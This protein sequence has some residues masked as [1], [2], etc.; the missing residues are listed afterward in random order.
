MWRIDIVKEHIK[1]KIANSVVRIELHRFGVADKE[2]PFRLNCLECRRYARVKFQ[3][4]FPRK[5][6]LFNSS[7]EPISNGSSIRYEGPE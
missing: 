7:L 2:A 3:G 1:T 5:A 6:V 4:V